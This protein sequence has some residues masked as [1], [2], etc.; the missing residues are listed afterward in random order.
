MK[1]SFRFKEIH[2]IQTY[3]RHCQMYH[4]YKLIQIVLVLFS[5]QDFNIFTH[6]SEFVFI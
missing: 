2:L 3:F 6:A 1:I 5:Y 4:L